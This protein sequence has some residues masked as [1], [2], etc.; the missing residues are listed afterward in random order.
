M[1]PAQQ[2]RVLYTLAGCLMLTT[3]GLAFTYAVNEKRATTKASPVMLAPAAFDK[4]WPTQDGDIAAVAQINGTVEC[5]LT[6]RG[7]KGG[8]RELILS[9]PPRPR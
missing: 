2:D 8:P 5:A 6:R 3:F 1:T 4:C 9:I 7:R